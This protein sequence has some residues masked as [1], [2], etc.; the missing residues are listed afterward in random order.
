MRVTL[1]LNRDLASLVAMNALIHH[2][3]DYAYTVF[4]SAK[5]GGLRRTEHRSLKELAF[6]E[7]TLFNQI[8]MPMMDLNP[9]ISGKWK[10]FGHFQRHGIRIAELT[11]INS[12]AG[13]QKVAA[14]KPNVMVSIRFGQ[15][16]QQSIID[17]PEHGV[18]NL[19]SGKLPEYRGVM[20]TFWAML[21]SAPEIA[22]TLHF[23]QDRQ[24]DAGDIVKISSLAVDYQRSYLW[25]LL[26]LYHQGVKDIVECLSRIDNKQSITRVRADAG[27][28]KY[29]SFPQQ[30]DL[31]A[32][33]ELGHKLIDYD[34]ITELAGN[35]FPA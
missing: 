35:F 29:F 1:L 10:T 23:I 24:I 17:I 7:Q 34:E 9:G 19:H 28:G 22:S 8:V 26:S 14:N 32:F 30:A 13:Y 4:V 18:I 33:A 11:D 2:A 31:D 25:N 15:I 20:A 3:P 5:V 21:N 16:L 6:F 27:S 12:Q